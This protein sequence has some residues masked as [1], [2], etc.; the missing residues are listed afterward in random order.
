MMTLVLKSPKYIQNNLQCF[1]SSLDFF[2]W[3]GGG[4]NLSQ[5]RREGYISKNISHCQCLTRSVC[6]TV[7]PRGERSL[8]KAPRYEIIA[9]PCKV[10]THPPHQG[11]VIVC[12]GLLLHQKECNADFGLRRVLRAHF[13]LT[14]R[15]KPT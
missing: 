1:L 4:G 8:N 11:M 12:P 2:W 13:H 15:G 6:L 14:P 5:W 7:F 3:G 9:A 10:Y